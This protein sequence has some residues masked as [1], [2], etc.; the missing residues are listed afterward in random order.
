MKYGPLA[1]TDVNL[2]RERLNAHG[3]DLD[4][5]YSDDDIQRQ[6]AERL[7]EEPK[8]MPTAKGPQ[9][10]LYVEIAEEDLPL[11][12]DDLLKMGIHAGDVESLEIP[13]V[14]EYL[15]P[16]CDFMR[17]EPGLCP[18]HH[19]PLLEFSEYVKAKRDLGGKGNNSALLWIV[20]AA[21]VV[22]YIAYSFYLK[23]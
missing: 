9:L 15:C 12:Q 17:H 22:G 2:L 14:P 21:G 23:G 6:Q 5:S 16:V 1:P 18:T 11:V 4:V 19:R 7:A 13:E 20:I 10:Y 8:A 3:K